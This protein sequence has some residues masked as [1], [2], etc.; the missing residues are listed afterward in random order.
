M[1]KWFKARERAPLA[2]VI[3]Y[4]ESTPGPTIDF[5]AKRHIPFRMSAGPT[6][7]GT[8]DIYRLELSL[9]GPG[10]SKITDQSYVVV[11]GDVVQVMTPDSF[12]A[13]YDVAHPIKNSIGA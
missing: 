13:T 10:N 2:D 1:D 9:P 12:A 7:V 4:S 11:H 5:L 8:K 3:R 6:N